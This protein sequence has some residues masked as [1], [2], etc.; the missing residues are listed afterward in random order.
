MLGAEAWEM[1]HQSAD[2]GSQITGS[3]SARVLRLSDSEDVQGEP[4]AQ[5]KE[6]EG[7]AGVVVVIVGRGVIKAG[8]HSGADKSLML[9]LAPHGAWPQ[10]RQRNS[11]EPGR[12]EAVG[13]AA[14]A[15]GVG[16]GGS[17]SRGSDAGRRTRADSRCRGA[18]AATE[19]GRALGWGQLLTARPVGPR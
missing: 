4:A 7:V 5:G 18:G 13:S 15:R 1:K 6:Q 3:W 2:P 14:V 12:K 11:D 10:Q 16:K 9:N 17:A 19:R 8:P